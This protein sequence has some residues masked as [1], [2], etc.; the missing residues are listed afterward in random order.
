M[1]SSPWLYNDEVIYDDSQFPEKT[2]GFVYRITRLSDGKIYYGKKLAFFTKTAIK[3]VTLKNG[4]K[5]KKKVRTQVPSDWKTYWSSSPELQK[6]V[7]TLGESA[8]S[9]EI[10]AFCENRG[11]LSYY[12][13]RYQMDARVL[14]IGDKSYN[15]IVN[16]RCHWTHVRPIL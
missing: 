7:Q 5:K 11:S 4:T 13:L 9:R 12:E 10:L 16:I 3:T 15:G 2:L 14:E 8:F 6:D 1:M